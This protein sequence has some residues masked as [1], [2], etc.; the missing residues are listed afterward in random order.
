MNFKK[1]GLT[2]SLLFTCITSVSCS[3]TSSSE[4]E[5]YHGTDPA[6]I[7]DGYYSE[8]TTWKNY[9]DLGQKLYNIIYKD[10]VATPYVTSGGAN[11]DT[12]RNAD[13]SLTNYD[14]VH[15]LY[16]DEEEFKQTGNTTNWQRE[17]CFPA[18]LMTGM[19]TG[20]ATKIVGT[21]TDFH[22]LYASYSSA[23]S[24]HSNDCYGYV[25]KEK[26]RQVGSAYYIE[27]VAF[28]PGDFDKG[29][30][31]RAVLYIGVMYGRESW[32][33]KVDN[34]GHELSTGIM[35][36]PKSSNEKCSLQSAVIGKPCHN[37]REDL[38]EWNNKFLP[39]RLELQH[40]NYVQ[41][42]QHNRNPFVDFPGLVDY[43]Y[44]DKMLEAGD[45]RNIPNIY[46]ILNLGS[47]ET[48]NIA[49]KNVK[50]SYNGGDI[51]DST[52][53]L[54]IYSVSNSFKV[55][56]LTDYVISG[57][58]DQE[59]IDDTY[60]S[61]KVTISKG[62]LS[63]SYKIEIA[64]KAWNNLNYSFMA[65]TAN[66]AKGEGSANINGINWNTSTGSAKQVKVLDQNKNAVGVNI[67]SKSSPAGSVT[68]ETQAPVEVDGNYVVKEIY[69]EANSMHRYNGSFKV[70]ISLGDNI[71]FDKSISHSDEVT[72]QTI[73]VRLSGINQG[74]GKVKIELTNVNTGLRIGR[75]GMLVSKTSD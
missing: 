33:K 59:P 39:D 72:L 56:P 67:G 51:Y 54:E 6:T 49:V 71:V 66:I 3:T 7:F 70:T 27:D 37:N 14:K 2:L 12:N 63:F 47:D 8:L 55:E 69:I 32:V 43:L 73:G 1:L 4:E 16:S 40:C 5:V 29:R 35:I 75:V 13:Q 11:W 68:L 10:F 18:S 45:L 57:V 23:N 28:E 36:L 60:T 38:V 53:D 46:D 22:N 52:K 30:V 17:H 9:I 24:A 61:K 41:S 42:Q 50:Y 19:G 34:A 25:D 26:A 20:D 21:A 31:A 64:P 58:V 15:L 44:G 48:Y 62:D 74:V 65:S